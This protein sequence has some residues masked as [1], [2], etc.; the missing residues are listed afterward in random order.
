MGLTS[1]AEVYGAA[2]LIPAKQMMIEAEELD[3]ALVWVLLTTNI[4]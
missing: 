1:T 4:A 3:L 2:Y